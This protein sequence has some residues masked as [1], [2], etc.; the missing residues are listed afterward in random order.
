[1]RRIPPV[2]A[3]VPTAGL[4]PPVETSEPTSDPAGEHPTNLNGYPNSGFFASLCGPGSS[5]ETMGHFTPNTVEN[6]N[7]KHGSGPQ[8]Y[9]LGMADNEMSSTGQYNSHQ[10]LIYW[11]LYSAEVDT[12]NDFLDD[13]Y[14]TAAASPSDQTWWN[15]M[16]TDVGGGPESHVPAIF[17]ANTTYLDGWGNDQGQQH[18]LTVTTL[19]TNGNNHITYYDTATTY[20]SGG[21]TLGFHD[22]QRSQID[23]QSGGLLRSIW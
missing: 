13:N 7:S 11:T 16:D 15:E 9:L 6:W 20:A 4:P 8:A 21:D 2:A 3:A 5:T 23:G 19:G 22:V 1:M 17:A 14:Y 12:I 10:Q 18:F